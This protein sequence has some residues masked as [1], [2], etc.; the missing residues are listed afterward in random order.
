[1]S[2]LELVAQIGVPGLG[3]ANVASW[4]ALGISQ[5][6]DTIEGKGWQ[7]MSYIGLGRIS[8]PDNYAI[9]QK[10]AMLVVNQ[11]FYHQ[12]HHNW[13]YSFGL[14]YRL[15]DEYLDDYP[16]T[17]DSPRQKQE[18]R[19]YARL[20]YTYKKGPIKLVPTLGHDFR[21]FCAPNFSRV[22]E[23]FQFRSRVRLQ[24]TINLD[25][26]KIHRLIF[27]SEHFFSISKKNYPNRWTDFNYRESRFSVHYSISPKS[28]PVIFNVGYMNNLMGNKNP[29]SVHYLAADI[30]IENPFK[31]KKR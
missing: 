16:Y 12:F 2:T 28:I 4:F 11:E 15:R 25:A 7:S 21:K 24:L 23:D 10:Q 13:Q 6:L 1:L 9:F 14:S 8:N 3:K 18:F 26:Q 27:S 19:T 20:S 31:L 30:I 5:K 29:Y 22:S 17:H